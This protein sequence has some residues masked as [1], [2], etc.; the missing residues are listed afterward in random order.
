MF[1]DLLYKT[2]EKHSLCINK[3]SHFNVDSSFSDAFLTGESIQIFF[4]SKKF[5]KTA[6]KSKFFL[7]VIQVNA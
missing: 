2:L 6:Y 7:K 1:L 4:S 5:S 3:K